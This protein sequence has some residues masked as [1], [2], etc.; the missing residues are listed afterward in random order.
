MRRYQ[1]KGAPKGGL[2]PRR[3]EAVRVLLEHRHG[4]I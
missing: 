1:D 2:A 4:M 3:T